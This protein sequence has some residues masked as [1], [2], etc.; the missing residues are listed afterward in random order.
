[1][2]NPF[3]GAELTLIGTDGQSKKISLLT[4]SDSEEFT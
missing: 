2:F 1:M 3:L 4:S